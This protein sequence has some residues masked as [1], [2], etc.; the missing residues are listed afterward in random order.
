MVFGKLIRTVIEGIAAAVDAV[1]V[2]FGLK[3]AEKDADCNLS[4]KPVG[5][6]TQTCTKPGSTQL[7]E[8]EAENLFS[9]LAEQDHIPFDYPPDCCYSRAHEMCRIIESKGIECRKYWL[10]DKNWGEQSKMRAS[11]APVDKADNPI[12]FPDPKGNA[13][14][15]FAFGRRF[16]ESRELPW[17]RKILNDQALDD[18]EAKVNRLYDEGMEYVR[19]VADVDPEDEA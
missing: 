18:P 5:A 3:K 15:L 6:P 4:N 7:S 10:F 1:A 11:L 9:E 2:F 17:A 19:Q 12:A 8:T 14:G 13:I 16:D